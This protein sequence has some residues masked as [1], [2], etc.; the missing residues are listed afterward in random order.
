MQQM[1]DNAA[2]VSKDVKTKLKIQQR[3]KKLQF[4]KIQGKEKH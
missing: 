2:D 3:R 4:G 1:S